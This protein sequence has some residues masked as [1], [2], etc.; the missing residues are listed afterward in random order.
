MQNLMSHL[1]ELKEHYLEQESDI[2]DGGFLSYLLHLL[3]IPLKTPHQAGDGIF[4]IKVKA[5]I[6]I[7]YYNTIT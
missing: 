2:G 1:R 4:C 6:K 3:T 5:Y 7:L